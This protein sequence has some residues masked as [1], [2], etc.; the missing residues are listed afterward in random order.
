MDEPSSVPSDLPF[1]AYCN[2]D[3]ASPD[4]LCTESALSG[5]D[6]P[7]S[8]FEWKAE[9]YDTL[10]L[11]GDVATNAAQVKAAAG[12][13]AAILG[14]FFGVSRDFLRDVA[15]GRVRRWLVVSLRG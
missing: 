9:V 3:N 2:E 8:I 7:S 15:T 10:A 6:V 5:V 11:L 13:P 12:I 1:K 4:L 14:G